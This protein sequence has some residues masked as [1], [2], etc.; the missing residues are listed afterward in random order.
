[1]D[2]SGEAYLCFYHTLSHEIFIPAEDI[3]ELPENVVVLEIPY[4]LKLDPVAVARCYGMGETDFLRE[5]PI[6]LSL[7][8]KVIPLSESGLPE[9]IENNLKK[10]AYKQASDERQLKRG[11]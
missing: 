4:E 3:T 6:Q 10:R 8:A 9:F 1:M 7:V 11:R 2:G 5:H